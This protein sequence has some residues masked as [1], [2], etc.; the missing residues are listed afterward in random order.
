MWT[1]I[2][3]YSQLRLKIIVIRMICKMRVPLWMN[4]TTTLT[5]IGKTNWNLMKVCNGTTVTHLQRKRGE[6]NLLYN[7]TKIKLL[8]VKLHP[9]MT[10]KLSKISF[11]LCYRSISL[12]NHLTIN[13]LKCLLNKNIFQDLILGK[14]FQSSRAVVLQAHRSRALSA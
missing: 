1:H 3:R 12:S 7:H 2:S 10:R 5:I 13:R 4:I 9:N 14:W 6:R 11:S 8:T